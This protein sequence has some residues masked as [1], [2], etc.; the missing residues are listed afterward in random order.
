MTSQPQPKYSF[1]LGGA[2]LFSLPNLLVGALALAMSVY[3]PRHYA[4][5]LGL[6][7]ATV[8]AAFGIVRMIDIVFDPF[9]GLVMDKTRT[10]FGRYRV[11]LIAGG[12]LFMIGIYMLFMAQEGVDQLYMIFWLLILYAGLSIIALSHSSWASVLAPKYNERSRLFGILQAL[13]VVGATAVLLAPIFLANLNPGEGSTNHVPAMGW[14]MI[15]ATPITIVLAILRTPEKIEPQPPGESFKLKEYWDLIVEPSMLRLIVA[16]FCLAMGPGWMSALYLFF[17]VDYL[18]FSQNEANILLL[19][20]IFAGIIGAIVLGRLAEM[21]SKHRTLMGASTLYSLGL[22]VLPLL[23]RGE[24][25]PTAILMFTLGGAAVGFSLLT[26]AM[27]ADVGDLIRLEQNKQ[28]VGLL[29]ALI[30]S[31]QKIAGAVSIMLTFAVLAWVGYNAQEGAANTPEA[32]NGLF[33]VY[34]LGPIVFVMLGGACFI[35]YGLDD[36]RHEEIRRDLEQRDAMLEQAPILESMTGSDIL[37]EP[38]PQ[39]KA[40]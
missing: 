32:V 14:F 25:W 40:P 29:Y 3:L 24:F 37:H 16:D 39:P 1:P 5:H 30:T 17:F 8:G 15:I 11:W 20:Y 19:I 28:R 34:L 10:A 23:P 2:V 38:P 31:T 36:K 7:L 35:G 21:F 26:R 22:I 12:P 4:S 27:T 9:L 33:W 13:G 18:Q 6:S